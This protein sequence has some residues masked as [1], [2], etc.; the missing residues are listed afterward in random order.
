MNK[1]A[2]YAGTFDPPTIGHVW[3]IEQGAALFDELNVVV[4]INP[5]KR[6]MFSVEERLEMLRESTESLPNITIGSYTNQFLMN[7][8]QSV[9][10]Q[11]MLRGIRTGSDFEYE[12][13]MRNIN[14]DLNPSLMTVFLIPPRNIAE[15]SSSLVKGLIGPMG[16][17]NIVRRYLTEPVFLKLKAAHEA[18]N[19]KPD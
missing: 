5:D 4:G 16:W 15:V 12:R 8:A 10:A 19:N 7:Y 2:I 9:G 18:K 17:E 3:M 14:G 13:A 6:C 1:L 11:F